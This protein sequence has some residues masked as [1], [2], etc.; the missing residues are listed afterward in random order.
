MPAEPT[1]CY[2]DD[3]LPVVTI[4]DFRVSGLGVL[5]DGFFSQPEGPRHASPGQRPGDSGVKAVSP[6]GAGQG[7]CARIVPPLQGLAVF[8]S[9]PRALPW[10]G[11]F[12][13]FE[14]MDRTD[15]QAVNVSTTSDI[16]I[17]NL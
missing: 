6:E 10:A 15:I 17:H 2:S 8:Q 3:I 13:L 1:T 7:L 16:K 12:R 9:I 5:A 4:C 14:P 11:L